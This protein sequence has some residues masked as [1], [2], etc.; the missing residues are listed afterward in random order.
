MHSFLPK[1]G[2]LSMLIT[3]MFLFSYSSP[4][5]AENAQEGLKAHAHSEIKTD[6]PPQVV[7]RDSV[8]KSKIA[9]QAALKA[10]KQKGKK[11]DLAK[12]IRHFKIAEKHLANRV[13]VKAIRHAV[14][15][16]EISNG[17]ILQNGLT[18]PKN[19]TF[20]KDEEKYRTALQRD[21]MDQNLDIEHTDTLPGL[22]DDA[23]LEMNIK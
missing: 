20:S 21:R 16:R 3:V 11:D 7:A 8:R 10:S 17:I 14:Y 2:H 19:S 23:A 12:A 1:T 22:T 9:L 18:L 4:I 15:S 5:W 6:S 13:Y